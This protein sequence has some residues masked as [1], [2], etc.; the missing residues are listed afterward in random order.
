MKMFEFS[1]RTDNGHYVQFSS[2]GRA[3]HYSGSLEFLVKHSA[4]R[5]NAPPPHTHTHTPAPFCL[6]GHTCRLN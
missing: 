1:L 2:G 6:C 3:A 4:R 5:D